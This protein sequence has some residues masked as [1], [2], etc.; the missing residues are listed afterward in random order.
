MPV[1]LAASAPAAPPITV[2]PQ[3]SPRAVQVYP[4]PQGSLV[5]DGHP[6]V[7]LVARGPRVAML[8]Q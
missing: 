5:T 8:V 1:Q 4:G 6:T 3:E 7:S 2:A